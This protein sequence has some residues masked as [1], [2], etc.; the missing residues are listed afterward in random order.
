MADIGSAESLIQ[1]GLANWGIMGNNGAGKS[2]FAASSKVRTLVVSTGVENIKPYRGKPNIT[3]QKLSR[4]DD[5]LAVYMQLRHQTLLPN[6]NPNPAIAGREPLIVFDTWSRMQGLA[7]DKVVGVRDSLTMNDADLQQLLLK[8]PT[9]PRGYEQWQQ[10]GGLSNIWMA[11]FQLLPIHKL[12]L[13]QIGTREPKVQGELHLTGPA[14]TPYAIAYVRESVEMLGLLYVE[15]SGGSSPLAGDGS[16]RQINPNAKETRRM[17]IGQHPAYTTKGPTHIL[18][19][20]VENPTW[21]KLAASLD[22]NQPSLQEEEEH[23][24]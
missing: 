21:D 1:A 14:L 24:L 20:T 7:M 19:Y 15:L 2:T 9:T 22:P 17:L 10:I 5:L 16:E 11:N 8:V 12:F 23:A 4:W 3:V 13:F 6:G 18:G